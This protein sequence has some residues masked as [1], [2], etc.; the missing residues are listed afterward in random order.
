MT[1]EK[2]TRRLGVELS[3]NKSDAIDRSNALHRKY[4]N[5][6]LDYVTDYLRE[7]PLDKVLV[8]DPIVV[9]WCKE[10]GLCVEKYS[11]KGWEVYASAI[12]LK[13]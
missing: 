13:A 8:Y 11:D 4:V 3:A 9:E 7:F 2:Y 10:I 12:K 1:E 5:A 6:A